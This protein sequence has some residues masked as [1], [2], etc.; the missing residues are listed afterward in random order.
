MVFSNRKACTFYPQPDKNEPKTL[1]AVAPV[2]PKRTSQKAIGHGSD[3][4]RNCSCLPRCAER[5]GR[6]PSGLTTAQS[7][8]TAEVIAASFGLSRRTAPAVDGHLCAG[9]A[10][11]LRCPARPR[12]L[13]GAPGIGSRRSP[14]P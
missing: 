11:P 8:D 9:Q 10:D 3:C 6:Q 7:S 13:A 1:W 12:R 5:L 2:A 4:G 14:I